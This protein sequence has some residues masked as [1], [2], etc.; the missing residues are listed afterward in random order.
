MALNKLEMRR[1]DALIGAAGRPPY[2]IDL[3]GL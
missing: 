3:N 1:M 2:R